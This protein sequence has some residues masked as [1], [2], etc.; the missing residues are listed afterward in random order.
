MALRAAPRSGWELGPANQRDGFL[1][2]VLAIA[3]MTR[4]ETMMTAY[5]SVRNIVDVQIDQ[6]Y[7]MMGPL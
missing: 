2:R 1:A 5:Q 4:Q 3:H 6:G 7:E